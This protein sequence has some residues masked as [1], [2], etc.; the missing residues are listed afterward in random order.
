MLFGI[1]LFIFI[2]VCVFLCLLILIQ[3]DKGGGLSGAIGGFGGGASNF[4]GTQDTA[5]I[6]TRGTAIFS[7]AFMVLCVVMSLLVSRTGVTAQRSMLEQRAQQHQSYSPS[8]AL[9][10]KALDFIDETEGETV[11]GTE[12]GIEQDLIP[13]VP[14]GDDQ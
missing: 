5:N 8:A 6:L 1:L 9:E 7:A 13:I 10:G 11:P 4:L 3:S 2:L 12:S 14:E